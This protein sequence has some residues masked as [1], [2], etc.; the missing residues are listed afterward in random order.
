MSQ[1][2]QAN[3]NLSQACSLIYCHERDLN[4]AINDV[5]AFGGDGEIVQQVANSADH[6]LAGAIHNLGFDSITTV[7]EQAVHRTTHKFVY[8]NL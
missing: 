7:R 3:N 2:T 1:F 4:E 8:F 5:Y 6:E